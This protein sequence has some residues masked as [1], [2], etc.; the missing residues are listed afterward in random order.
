MAIDTTITILQSI[1]IHNYIQVMVHHNTNRDIPIDANSNIFNQTVMD[2]N[3]TDDNNL[4]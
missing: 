4:V 1:F 2:K 3:S